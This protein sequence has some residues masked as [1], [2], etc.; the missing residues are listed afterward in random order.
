MELAAFTGWDYLLALVAGL[1]IVLGLLRG[2]VRTVFAL[3]AWLV[4]L[5][6]TPQIGPIAVEMAG[7][8][9]HE[10]VVLALT[11]IVLFAL[12]RL[13]GVLIAKAVKGVG[14][15]GAD[16][17]A[18]AL[19]GVAR[20]VVIIALVVAAARLTGLDQGAGWQQAVSRPLLDGIAA[21]IDP[22]LPAQP[23]HRI[24]ST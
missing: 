22:Y 15:G 16:R 3:G 17:F 7:F 21:A 12:V 19:F 18:G 4:A 11:F 20:A 5:L 23:K 9:E 1:S 10:W 13:I 6:G 8:E 14:L 24:Q 2:M